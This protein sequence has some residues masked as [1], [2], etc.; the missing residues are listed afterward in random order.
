MPLSP[1]QL[2]VLAGIPARLREGKSHL[3]GPAPLSPAEVAAAMDIAPEV[4]NH[5]VFGLIPIG[6]QGGGE[7]STPIRPALS[8][9]R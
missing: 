6:F 5:F 2:G 4:L 9:V 3:L 8:V 7:L 1:Y